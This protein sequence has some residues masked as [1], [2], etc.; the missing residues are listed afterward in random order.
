[1]VVP[2]C[3]RGRTPSSL[4]QG[5]QSGLQ[6][7]REKAARRPEGAPGLGLCVFACL[8]VCLSRKPKDVC[9]CLPHPGLNHSLRDKGREG[10]LF[11]V[12]LGQPWLSSILGAFTPWEERGAWRREGPAR[13]DPQLIKKEVADRRGGKAMSGG[14]PAPPRPRPFRYRC[15]LAPCA[16]APRIATALLPLREGGGKRGRGVP[17]G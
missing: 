5:P 6:E 11:A 3:G 15:A 17:R 13:L 7:S 12:G 14:G 4:P 10:S 1:M 2:R 9:T 16:L 8:S